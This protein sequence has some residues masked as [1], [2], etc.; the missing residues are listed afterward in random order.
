[1]IPAI[2]EGPFASQTSTVSA[3]KVRSTPS[4]VVIFSPSLARADGQRPAGDLV[5][6]E[7]VQRL[8]G[9]QH[10]VVGDVDDVVDRPLPGGAEPRLQPG[11]RGPDLHVGEDAGR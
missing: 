4:S 2:P 5:E 10:H 8:G 1:M 9:Q 11:R 7:G 6:V 3:S